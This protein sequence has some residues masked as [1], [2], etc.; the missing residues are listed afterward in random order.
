MAGGLHPPYSIVQEWKLKSNPDDPSDIH[1]W[2]LPVTVVVF[3]CLA[4]TALLARLYATI[5]GHRRCLALE[6]YVIIAAFVC[7]FSPDRPD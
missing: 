7:E 5:K 3:F 6:D 4:L 2:E 1:G